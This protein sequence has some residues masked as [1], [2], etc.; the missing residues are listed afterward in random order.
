[1]A[2]DKADFSG[3]LGGSSGEASS[4]LFFGEVGFSGALA[5]SF[6]ESKFRFGTSFLIFDVLEFG[7]LSSGDLVRLL[8]SLC[9][10]GAGDEEALV[11]L[12][13]SLSGGRLANETEV[14]EPSLAF[15]TRTKSDIPHLIL[16][17]I[18]S[19]PSV[20]NLRVLAM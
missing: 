10:P 9:L 8:R 1:M 16:Y 2:E 11:S 5:S 20:G 6:T 19:E 17:L 15:V 4:S 13:K 7:D 12:E 18:F 3:V 14:Q